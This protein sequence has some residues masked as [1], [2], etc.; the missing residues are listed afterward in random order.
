MGIKIWNGLTP[1]LPAEIKIASGLTPRLPSAYQEVEWIQSSNWVYIDTWFKPNNNSRF[2]ADYQILDTGT[3]PM[4][5]YNNPS[6]YW[7]LINTDGWTYS[8]AAHYW[9]TY[10]SS[11]VNFDTRKKADLNKNV[12]SVDDVVVHTFTAQTFQMNIDCWIFWWNRNG[13]QSNSGSLKLWSSQIYDDW[14]LVRDFVPCYRIADWEI[15][16]YDLVNDTFYTNSWSGTFTKWDDVNVPYKD[17]KKVFLG[18]T[19]IRPSGRLPSTYQEVEYIESSWTQYINPWL[20]ILNWEKF[21]IDIDFYWFNQSDWIMFGQYRN[22]AQGNVMQ[23]G[24]ISSDFWSRFFADSPTPWTWTP[25]SYTA[26][27]R[28]N[29]VF[30]WTAPINQTYNPYLFAQNQG[31][32]AWISTARLYSCKLWIDDVLERDFVPCYRIADSVIWLYDVVNKVFYTNAG[33][34]TFTK[35]SDV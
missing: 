21:K 25:S 22:S 33:S 29:F 14:T 27:T 10:Y 20:S 28:Y 34:W 31:S 9:T 7:L 4:W 17:I 3:A 23:F 19:Q 11:T 18:S 30:E 26:N 8:A 24:I 15:W 35:W 5:C 2:V 6:S 12:F 1:R 13:T 32:I 16:L